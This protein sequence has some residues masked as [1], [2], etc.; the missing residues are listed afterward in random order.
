[1]E[2]FELRNPFRLVLDLQSG[3][4]GSITAPPPA[5]RDPTRKIVVIDPG[6][7]G[8]ETGATGPTGLREKEVALD[9]ARRVQRR[10]QRDRNLTVVLT[11][12]ED[13]LIGLDERTAIANHNRADLFLSIH[14]NASPRSTATG[15]ETYFL[16]NDATDDDARTLAA[17]EN[18]AAGVSE[19][20]TNAAND[21][22]LDLVLWDLA[23]NQFLAES[24]LLAER[25][26][27]HLNALTGTRDRGVRQAP[28]RVLMGAMMPAILIEAGFLSN[29]EEE[30]RFR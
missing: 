10:L 23:Q 17:L 22:N 15:A 16:S 19:N 7:G 4:V 18:R 29:V 27:W 2:S 6:H 12:D 25:V 30:E 13:R 20:Q 11:R 24:S 21:R 26:Q 1:Y 28:F 8:V 5:E 9:L 14:L 3:A